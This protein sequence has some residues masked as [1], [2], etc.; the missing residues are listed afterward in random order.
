MVLNNSLNTGF[1]TSGQVWTSNGPTAVPT[2]KRASSSFLGGKIL[3]VDPT[4][5]DAN[6]GTSKSSP[7]IQLYQAYNVAAVAFDTIMFAPGEIAVTTD[8]AIGVIDRDI[9]FEGV[10]NGHR[11]MDGNF[12]TGVPGTILNYSSG[13]VLTITLSVIPNNLSFSNLSFKGGIFVDMT[14][15]VF[16]NGGL[17]TMSFKNCNFNLTNS[18]TA[19]KLEAQT[20]GD[21]EAEV[22]IDFQDCLFRSASGKAFHVLGTTADMRCQ[23]D[24]KACNFSGE[25]NLSGCTNGG[26]HDNYYFSADC[27]ASASFKGTSVQHAQFEEVRTFRMVAPTTNCSTGTAFGGK[28]RASF[29][30]CIHRVVIYVDTNGTTS[31]MIVD[32]NKNGS[33]IISGGTK[34]SLASATSSAEGNNESPGGMSGLFVQGDLFTFDIDQIHTTPAQGLSIE[35]HMTRRTVNTLT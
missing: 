20:D 11:L 3:L 21:Q 10:G 14:V 35:L 9:S 28:W 2:F 17:S 15:P 27:R 7:F 34:I 31:S 16:N 32:I 4:H 29:D 30:G 33:S 13:T 25:V 6:D 8:P 24:F 18:N 5:P 26:L 23:F 19:F 1:G 22:A 12:M